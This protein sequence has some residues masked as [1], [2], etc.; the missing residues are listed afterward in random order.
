MTASRPTGHYSR[1]SCRANSLPKPPYAYRQSCLGAD[2]D[3]LPERNLA[4]Q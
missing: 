4:E 1:Y 2:M 3:M